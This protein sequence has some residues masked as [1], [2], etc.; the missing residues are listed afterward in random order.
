[1][2]TKTKTK[3]IKINASDLLFIATLVYLSQFIENLFHDLIQ[4]TPLIDVLP[5]GNVWWTLILR[6]LCIAAWSGVIYLAVKSSQKCGYGP[7][8]KVKNVKK[9][10]W[11]APIVIALLFSA[12]FVWSDGGIAIL[13]AKLKNMGGFIG[14]VSYPIFLAFQVALVVLVIALSQKA[15]ETIFPRAWHYIPFGGLFLGVCMAIV[16]LISGISSGGVDALVL[17][18]MLV[19]QTV[20]GV[21]YVLTGKRSVLAFPFIYL[22]FFI[23]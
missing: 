5:L 16:N 6:L 19:I 15:F 10:E 17:L 13:W 1:M 14:T 2:A 3:K 22:M 18:F 12:Y 23:L 21:V 8:E 7:V 11:I 9:S 20:F 4:W